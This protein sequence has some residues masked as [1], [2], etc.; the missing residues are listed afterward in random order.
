MVKK[1]D[2]GKDRKMI[3]IEIAILSDNMILIGIAD[4]NFSNG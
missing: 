3:G 2:M 4:H 1:C